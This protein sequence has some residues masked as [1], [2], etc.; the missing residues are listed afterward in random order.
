MFK[1]T[2]RWVLGINPG[3]D[4]RM[5]V[6]LTLVI[7]FIWNRQEEMFGC[8]KKTKLKNEN[9]AIFFS[10]TLIVFDLVPLKISFLINPLWIFFLIGLEFFWIFGLGFWI[11][12]I[13]TW[14]W[15]PKN[16]KPKSRLKIQKIDKIQYPDP[17]W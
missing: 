5:R 12:K 17:V 1:D 14:V 9:L 4:K 15:N 7:T 11:L 10:L 3:S 13:F 8:K 2:K 6:K 16:A